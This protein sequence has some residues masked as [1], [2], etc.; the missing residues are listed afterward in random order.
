MSF[1][2][3]HERVAA[4]APLPAMSKCR[5]L[6]SMAKE[7]TCC[8]LTDVG[9]RLGASIAIHRRNSFHIERDEVTN[10]DGANDAPYKGF[11]LTRRSGDHTLLME[12][13]S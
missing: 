4:V 2:L 1:D 6:V 9:G 12:S 10:K 13:A 3:E 8:Q 11:S 7:D 5:L